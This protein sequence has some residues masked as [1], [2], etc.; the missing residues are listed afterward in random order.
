MK[1]SH[2]FFGASTGFDDSMKGLILTK[3]SRPATNAGRFLKYA[4]FPRRRV[5]LSWIAMGLI[6]ASGCISLIEHW[7]ALGRQIKGFR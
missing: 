1:D 6:R 4:E 2:V 7:Q 3:G 5:P